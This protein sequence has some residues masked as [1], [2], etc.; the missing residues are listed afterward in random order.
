MKSIKLS[1]QNMQTAVVT[2]IGNDKVGIIAGV[3]AL[4]AKS[5][6]N[7]M[8]ISQTIMEEV[9]TMIMMVSFPS[10]FKD[11]VSLK[12]QLEGY[13]KD[14]ELTINIQHSDI[15]NTMHRI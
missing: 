6:I 3:S 2:V 12:E 7:I 13:G 8:D 14:Q 11:F 4:L 9:F 5:N 10:D 15:Y 1:D